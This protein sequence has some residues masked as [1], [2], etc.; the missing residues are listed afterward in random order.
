MDVD[1]NPN[2]LWVSAVPLMGSLIGLW[3]LGIGLKLSH[4]L[5]VL[6]TRLVIQASAVD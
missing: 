3:G 2:S 1:L 5:W 6:A 4:T